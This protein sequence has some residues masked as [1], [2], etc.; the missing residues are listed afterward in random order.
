M[1][2]LKFLKLSTLFP[3]PQACGGVVL[4]L[5]FLRCNVGL[6]R[7]STFGRPVWRWCHD[8]VAMVWRGCGAGLAEG[9]AQGV[10]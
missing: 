3:K 2:R 6:P 8:P 1:K 10:A 7:L 9:V 4:T 5:S